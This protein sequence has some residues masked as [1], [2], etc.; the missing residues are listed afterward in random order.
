MKTYRPTKENLE[1]QWQLL[2]ASSQILGRLA[3]QAATILTGKNRPDY[4]PNL[5]VGGHVV[6]I[7]AAKIKLSSHKAGH[8]VYYWHSHYP[9]GLR[10]QSYAELSAK[11]PTRVV[12]QAI[13]HM[14]PK[15]RLTKNR[16]KRLK[17]YSGSEHPHQANLK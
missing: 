1:R 17:I 6:I 15:N 10:Q 3:T 11:N 14:L 2:D 16:L 12:R 8:K 5:D 7:N 4:T 13:Q 9:G